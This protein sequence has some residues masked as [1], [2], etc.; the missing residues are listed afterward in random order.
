MFDSYLFQEWYHVDVQRQ[1][2]IHVN[3]HENLIPVD[4]DRHLNLRRKQKPIGYYS[5]KIFTG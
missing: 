2:V 5:R 3:V 4:V 1:Q